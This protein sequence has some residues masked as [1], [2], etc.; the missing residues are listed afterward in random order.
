MECAHIMGR[1]PTHVDEIERLLDTGY[2]AKEI[3]KN[4][5]I[6][7]ATV[8]RVIDKLKRSARFE[9]KNLFKDDFLYKYWQTLGNFDKTIKE[10]NEEIEVVKSKYAAI[11]FQIMEAMEGLSSKQA[12]SKAHLL[13]NLISCQSSRTNELI[14]LV[15]ARDKASD[16]KARVYNQGPVVNALDEWVNRTTP[17]MAE[18]PKIAELENIEPS[19]LNT[20]ESN[21]ISDEISDEDRKVLEE[22]EDDNNN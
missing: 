18:L 15:G 5:N 22:M 2:N 1:R 11:E 8:Y 13:A 16:A 19:K 17:T 6:S 14:K 9:F 20:S 4:T 21:D 10:C 7:S 3:I 12:V